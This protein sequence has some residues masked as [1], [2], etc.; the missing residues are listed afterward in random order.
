MN[1]DFSSKAQEKQRKVGLLER[2]VTM[3]IGRLRG[4]KSPDQ[5]NLSGSRPTIN[6]F[7]TLFTKTAFSTRREAGEF[8]G[9]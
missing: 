5:E 7:Q 6:L 4:D 1:V 8:R 3:R 2:L 9:V